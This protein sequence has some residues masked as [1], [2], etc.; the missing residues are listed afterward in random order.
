[1]EN[2]SSSLT[3]EQICP[4]Y[5]HWDLMFR[6]RACEF[7]VNKA[8]DHLGLALGDLGL[9]SVWNSLAYF[10]MIED[11]AAIINFWLYLWY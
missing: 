7:R 9:Y 3:D 8:E 11:F 5:V 4:D 2:N 10:K 6:V 1:M